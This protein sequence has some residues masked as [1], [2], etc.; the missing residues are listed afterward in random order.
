MTGGG[1]FIS[2]MNSSMRNN[3]LL[4]RK[5]TPFEKDKG[6]FSIK[7]K[8]LKANQTEIEIKNLTDEEKEHYR[9]ET[10]RKNRIRAIRKTALLTVIASVIILLSAFGIQH[11][12]TKIAEKRKVQQ[13][14]IK[15][16]NKEQYDDY[17]IKAND[18]IALQEWP[19]AIWQLK[20][21]YALSSVKKDAKFL[22]AD[23]YLKSCTME[24]IYCK[25]GIKFL[26]QLISDYPDN[27]K[28]VEMRAV[29]YESTGQTEKAHADF[30]RISTN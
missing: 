20:K 14:I 28:L 3:S 9:K 25:D 19:E 8:L 1:G 29:L 17:M 5:K 6:I 26:S 2:N 10:N 15:E 22:L 23:V 30:E 21:A 12:T 13:E 24:Q 18:H 7:D 11:L 16:R 27:M 4:R